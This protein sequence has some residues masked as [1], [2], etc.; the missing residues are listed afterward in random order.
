MALQ[1]RCLSLRDL[2][3]GPGNVWG[4]CLAEVTFGEEN[5]VGGA[6]SGQSKGEVP[7]VGAKA[8]R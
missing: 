5:E 6:S 2:T 7:S 1:P 4:W 8:C 3:G